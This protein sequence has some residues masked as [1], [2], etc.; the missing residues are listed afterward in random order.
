MNNYDDIINLSRPI[1][2][3]PKMSIE[4]RSSLFSSFDPLDGYDESIQLSNI[5][6]EEK[7]ILTDEEKEII[8]EK[9][10]NK[11]SISSIIYYDNSKYKYVKV[12]YKIK[13][14]DI[15]N[16]MVILENNNKIY[17]DDIK[18]VD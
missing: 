9:L 16:K 14:I 17:I 5:I 12:N 11:E 1:S 8:N 10:N 15:L 7:V 2:K 13:K 18:K 6:K 4:E 3:H